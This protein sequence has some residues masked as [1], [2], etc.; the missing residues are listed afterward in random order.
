MQRASP[1]AFRSCVLEKLLLGSDP[2]H[3]LHVICPREEKEAAAG[4]AAGVKTGLA[5][6]VDPRAEEEAAAGAAAGAAT[7]AGL[8]GG[9]AAGA[10]DDVSRRGFSDNCSSLSASLFSMAQV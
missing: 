5:D 10:A 4:A 7:A 8:A 1:L 2:R 9:A 3:V 6:V